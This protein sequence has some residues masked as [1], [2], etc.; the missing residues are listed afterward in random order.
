MTVLG[1]YKGL[2]EDDF[3]KTNVWRN[4][5]TLVIFGD[6]WE[7]EKHEKYENDENHKKSYITPPPPP[8][9]I[10]TP[11]IVLPGWKWPRLW[12]KIPSKTKAN[13]DRPLRPT[14]I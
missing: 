5:S 12:C 13:F 7:C 1:F 9:I 4:P 14:S 10:S 8:G 2:D 3:M 6:F 11:K